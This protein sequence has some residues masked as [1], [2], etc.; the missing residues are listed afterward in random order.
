MEFIRLGETDRG[1]MRRTNMKQLDPHKE[2]KKAEAF[3]SQKILVEIFM[4]PFNWNASIHN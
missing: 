4:L 2:E 1:G 3:D